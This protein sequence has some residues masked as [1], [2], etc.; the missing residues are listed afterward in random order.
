MHNQVGIGVKSRKKLSSKNKQTKTSE[1]MDV[2]LII[3]TKGV[4]ST[5]I[6]LKIGIDK[7]D[8]TVALHTGATGINMIFAISL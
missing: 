2:S 3:K 8:P 6:R 5:T 4:R 1:N 7:G